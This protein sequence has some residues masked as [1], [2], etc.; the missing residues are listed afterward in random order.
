[1]SGP[2]VVACLVLTAAL[3]LTGVVL[4]VRSR[5]RSDATGDLLGLM[6]LMAAGAPAAAYGAAAG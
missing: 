4:L 5:R 3:V 1:V 2:A 6:A